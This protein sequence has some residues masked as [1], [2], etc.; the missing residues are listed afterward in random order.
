MTI[1]KLAG[2]CSSCG[3]SCCKEEIFCSK[4]CQA[5]A[6]WEAKFGDREAVKPYELPTLDGLP[7]LMSAGEKKAQQQRAE[8]AEAGYRIAVATERER[9][10]R[11]GRQN[12]TRRYR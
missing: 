5:N 10:A 11:S 12:K 4:Q 3:Q 8:A 6:A 9:Q 7:I 2:T 1:N